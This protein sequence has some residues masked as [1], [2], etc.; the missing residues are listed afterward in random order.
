M[1]A[2]S[3]AKLVED[4]ANEAMLISLKQN[5]SVLVYSGRISYQLSV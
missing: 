4:N 2:K 1:R 5:F 3:L